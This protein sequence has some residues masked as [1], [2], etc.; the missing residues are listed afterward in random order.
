MSPMAPTQVDS[1]MSMMKFKFSWAFF[2]ERK[3]NCVNSK[4]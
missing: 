2:W 1:S 3:H 4:N